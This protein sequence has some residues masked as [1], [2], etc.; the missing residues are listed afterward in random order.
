MFVKLFSKKNPRSD[1]ELIEAYKETRD[2]KFVGELF[3]RYT[4]LVYGVCLKYLKDEEDSKDAVLL[5]FEKLLTDLLR[6]EIQ[7]FPPWLHR[8]T[9]NYCLMYLRQRKREFK[10]SEDYFN[11]Q[12]DERMDSDPDWHLSNKS[13]KHKKEERLNSIEDALHTLNPEQKQCVELFFLEEKSYQEIVELT[14][15][16][17]SKVKSFLQNGKRN[18]KKQLGILTLALWILFI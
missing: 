10:R 2:N 7:N 9:Q 12:D 3:E 14:G 17:L 8:L 18:I 11:N 15:F 4:H 1:L 13:E 6:F 16:S 5:I